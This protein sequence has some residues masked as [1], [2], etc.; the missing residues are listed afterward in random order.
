VGIFF[1]E[2]CHETVAGFDARGGGGDGGGAGKGK[3]LGAKNTF[4]TPLFAL[5][6]K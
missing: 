3:M 4:L 1:I 2:L 6:K 5:E